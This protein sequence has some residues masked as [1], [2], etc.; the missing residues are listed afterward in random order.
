[1]NV[2]RVWPKDVYKAPD[3]GTGVPAFAQV[4]EVVRGP[5][6]RSIHIAGTYGCDADMVFTSSDMGGQVRDA[7]ENIRRSLAAVGAAPS[8]VVRIKTYTTDLVAFRAEGGPVFVDFWAGKPPVSTSIQIVAL[9][10]GA[11]VEME[12]Y[13][14]LE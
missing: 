9:H 14:E 8:D 6:S 11:L 4:V 3:R 5:S 10:P 7:L 12:A 13:A 2:N 1:M